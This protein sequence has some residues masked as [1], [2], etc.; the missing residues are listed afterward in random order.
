MFGS[1]SGQLSAPLRARPPIV[2]VAAS[3][4]VQASARARSLMKRSCESSDC[5]RKPWPPTAADVVVTSPG[6]G[7]EL[8]D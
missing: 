7:P 1:R 4:A 8:P 3:E 2:Y 6:A 5:A